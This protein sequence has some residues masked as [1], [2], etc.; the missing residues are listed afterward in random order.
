MRYVEMDGKMVPIYEIGDRV[1]KVVIK[2]PRRLQ[3]RSRYFADGRVK[4]RPE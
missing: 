4:D 3:D 2:Y 1:K